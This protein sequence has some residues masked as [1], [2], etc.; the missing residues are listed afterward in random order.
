MKFPDNLSQ[1]ELKILYKVLKDYGS[2]MCPSTLIRSPEL[3]VDEIIKDFP[4]Y[5]HSL[6]SQVVYKMVA[7]YWLIEKPDECGIKHYIINSNKLDRIK[8]LLFD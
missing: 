7:E 5:L 8:K 4:D 3:T 2:K 1:E 6:A